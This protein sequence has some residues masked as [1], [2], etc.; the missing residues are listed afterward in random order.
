MEQHFPKP[1]QHELQGQ[2][3]K[4]IGYTMLA[5]R[6]GSPVVE[7]L[8]CYWINLFL[9]MFAIYWSL[10]NMV[11]RSVVRGLFCPDIITFKFSF[12]LWCTKYILMVCT[13]KLYKEL[14]N[15][16]F[17]K[18]PSRIEESGI[19][20]HSILLPLPTPPVPSLKQKHLGEQ[21]QVL[22]LDY[23]LSLFSLT[24]LDDWEGILLVISPFLH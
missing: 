2:L 21:S 17:S 23:F 8:V 18:L 15:E 11:P 5:Q 22:Q 12:R 7:E 10:W 16:T 9:W 13:P 6:A 24:I 4:V 19:S 3:F 1:E 20:H 14:H